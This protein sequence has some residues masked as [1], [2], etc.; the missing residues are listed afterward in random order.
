M[1]HYAASKAGLSAYV[2]A[3]HKEIRPLG[4]RCVAFECGGFPTNL[5]QPRESST[6][7]GFGSLGPSVDDYAPLFGKLVSKF[8]TN[9]MAHMPGDVQK[10]ADRIIDTIKREG[11][12]GQRSWAIR[13][14]LGSDGLGSAKQ[15]AEEQLKLIEIWKDV[16]SSTDREEGVESVANKEMFEFTTILEEE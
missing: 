1:S 8:A 4:L 7:E 13:V 11:M 3:L 5:G 15:K 2:E 14:A 10:A 12:V 16:S 6:G 9:P